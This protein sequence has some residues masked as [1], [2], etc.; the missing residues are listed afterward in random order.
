MT[1][2]LH[3]PGSWDCAFDHL[4]GYGAVAIARACGHQTRIR[5]TDDL[6]STAEITG[7][8]W[9]TLASDVHKHATAHATD[10][11]LQAD[12]KAGAYVKALFSPRVPCLSPEQQ[13]AWFDSRQNAI[14]ALHQPWQDLDLAMIGSLGIPS[15]WN[16]N[17]K[18]DQNQDFGANPWEMA[19]RNHG[20]EFIGG[21][22]RKL[23]AATAART[24]EAVEIGLRESGPIIDEAGDNKLDSRTPTGLKP[25]QTTDNARAWCALWGLS[26]LTVVP[27]LN[28]PSTASCYVR[29][30]NVEAV[31]LPLMT[32]WWP[33]TR[34][35]TILNSTQ[36][37]SV[38]MS[39]LIGIDPGTIQARFSDQWLM[40]RGVSAVV[41]FPISRSSN[42]SAPERWA[43]FGQRI[44]LTWN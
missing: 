19:T 7:I 32:A 26:L 10:S 12:G 14:D 8:D 38:I 36:L 35:R 29:H 30:G 17:N 3:F 6:E 20:Q 23:A 37:R 24:I 39:N 22:L 25:P 42:P 15:Y 33:L 2:V 34:L 28:S 1:D 43:N 41:A 18:G 13:I 31:Y 44:L 16:L 5:W 9:P 27:A 40:D 4:C 11:W 21:R